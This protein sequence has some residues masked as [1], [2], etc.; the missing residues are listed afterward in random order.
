M[1]L[2]VPVRPSSLETKFYLIQATAYPHHFLRLPNHHP[3]LALN[4]KVP[5][6]VCPLITITNKLITAGLGYRSMV[7]EPDPLGL[8]T[9]R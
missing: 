8:Q 2:F 4:S 6:A 9:T 3:R 7:P 1:L 5:R